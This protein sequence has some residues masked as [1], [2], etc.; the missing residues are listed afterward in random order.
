MT[1]ELEPQRTSLDPVTIHADLSEWII[2][3]T[4]ETNAIISEFDRPSGLACQVKPYYLNQHGG[5]QNKVHKKLVA[6][7]APTDQD[8]PVFPNYNLSS[9]V[10]V[11]KL[12][13]QLTDIKVPKVLWEEASIDV[14]GVP[15]L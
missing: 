3:A 4:G 14:L 5:S 11:M 9:Q 8:I 15:S 6:R 13:E 12:V 10:K 7:L 1:N 2:K